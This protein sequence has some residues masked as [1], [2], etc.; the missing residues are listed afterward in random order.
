MENIMTGLFDLLKYYA[1]IGGILGIC[2]GAFMFVGLAILYFS[3]ENKHT[4][5]YELIRLFLILFFILSALSIFLTGIYGVKNSASIKASRLLD[6]QW[7]VQLETDDSLKDAQQNKK[8]FQ[9][10][11]SDLI[12]LQKRENNGTE[13]KF[14]TF[15]LYADDMDADAGKNLAHKDWQRFG[16]GEDVKNSA[17]T[18]NLTD[19]CKEFEFVAESNFYKCKNE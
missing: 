9:P 18:K 15:N 6:K 13:P 10:D 2:I 5:V 17:S 16:Y 12:I 4:K 8:R 11:F 14:Y 3:K 1:Q 7:A 19:L